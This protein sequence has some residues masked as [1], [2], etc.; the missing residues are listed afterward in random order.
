MAEPLEVKGEPMTDTDLKAIAAVS[1]DDV[2]AAVDVWQQ[3]VK[4]KYKYLL[5]AKKV[6]D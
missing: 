4:G 2:Q 6:K 5:V 1:A 3:K